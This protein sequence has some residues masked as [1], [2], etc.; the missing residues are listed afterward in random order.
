VRLRPDRSPVRSGPLVQFDPVRSRNLPVRL[1]MESGANMQLNPNPR[2]PEHPLN[3]Q[4][5]DW[6]D[7]SHDTVL[8]LESREYEEN[9]S[10]P[11]PEAAYQV[12]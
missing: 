11:R 6:F 10:S 9:G 5:T 8:I 1:T 7:D 12:A 2:Q 4:R 3:R